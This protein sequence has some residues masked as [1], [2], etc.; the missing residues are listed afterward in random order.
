MRRTY[1]LFKMYADVSCSMVYKTR[2][3]EYI[4][5]ES[6]SSKNTNIN[7]TSSTSEHNDLRI[8][9]FCAVFRRVA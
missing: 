1:A 2:S 4:L 3:A 7:F 5:T 6:V 9:A 8:N